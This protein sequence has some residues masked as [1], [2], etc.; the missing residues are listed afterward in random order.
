M[1]THIVLEGMTRAEAKAAGLPRYHGKPCRVHGTTERYTAHCECC[2][3]ARVRTAKDYQKHLIKRRTTKAAYRAEHREEAR[4][5]TAKWATENPDLVRERAAKW[6]R[7]NRDKS[8]AKRAKR[9][10]ALVNRTPAWADLKAIARIYTEAQRLTEATGVI[11]HV[12]HIIPLHGKTVS[13]LHVEG[14]LQIL[15]ARDNLR[16]SNRVV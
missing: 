7:D 15:T 14:N 2:E 13:G 9:R 5:K 6:H 12:D 4:A 3:C 10:A 11:H 16:K 8:R 1:P